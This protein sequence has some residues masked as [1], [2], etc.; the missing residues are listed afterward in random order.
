MA[1]APPPLCGSAPPPPG[2]APPQAPPLPAG[3]GAP[4]P[5]PPA[6]SAGRDGGSKRA[7]DDPPRGES[8]TSQKPA[9]LSASIARTRLGT[10]AIGSPKSR[11]AAATTT[12]GVTPALRS[13]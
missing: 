4:P 6:T 11:P 9:A 13:R 2:G 7:S 1:P 8:P 5:P 3:G 10:C 12:T